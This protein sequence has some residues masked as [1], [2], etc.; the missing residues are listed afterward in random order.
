[1]EVCNINEFRG[2]FMMAEALGQKFRGKV[3]KHGIKVL[4]PGHDM[5]TIMGN[6]VRNFDG[7]SDSCEEVKILFDSACGSGHV[8]CRASVREG[9]W[10]MYSVSDTMVFHCP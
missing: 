7:Y 4:C 3:T 2:M 1:M 8:Y 5:V 6:M 9:G 10:Y